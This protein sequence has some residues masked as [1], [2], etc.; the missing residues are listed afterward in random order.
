MGD[1]K[2]GGAGKDEERAGQKW[3]AIKQLNPWIYTNRQTV[4]HI[5][6]MPSLVLVVLWEHITILQV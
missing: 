1:D 3:M 4:S 5:A 2:E 6:T